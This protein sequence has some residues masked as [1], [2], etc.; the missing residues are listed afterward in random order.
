MLHVGYLL[1]TLFNSSPVDQTR[2]MKGMVET[3]DTNEGIILQRRFFCDIEKIR[4]M[5]REAKA[6]DQ[7]QIV[8]DDYKVFEVSSS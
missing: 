7:E 5:Q 3:I 6:D 1:P 8:K 2:L 4:R